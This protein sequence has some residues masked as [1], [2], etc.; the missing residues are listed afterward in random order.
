MI[1]NYYL[2]PLAIQMNSAFPHHQQKLVNI[3][4]NRLLGYEVELFRGMFDLGK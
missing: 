4:L 2:F 1:Q 3:Y